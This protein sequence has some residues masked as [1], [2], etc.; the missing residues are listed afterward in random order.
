MV[1]RFKKAFEGAKGAKRFGGSTF[2]PVRLPFSSSSCRPLGW[3]KRT[4]QK[5]KRDSSPNE[6]AANSRKVR[7]KRKVVTCINRPPW[8]LSHNPLHFKTRRLLQHATIIKMACTHHNHRYHD[9]ISLRRPTLDASELHATPV[10][11]HLPPHPNQ[12]HHHLPL[13][14]TITPQ[15]PPHM[16]LLR[17]KRSLPH[18]GWR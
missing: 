2:C 8:Q 10:N 9:L 11:I 4:V 13:A 14:P 5:G 15:P 18:T 12:S 3:T 7:T 6:H 1:R 17:P 16:S